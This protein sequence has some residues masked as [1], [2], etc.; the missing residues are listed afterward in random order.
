MSLFRVTESNEV[1]SGYLPARVTFRV[2]EDPKQYL[3]LAQS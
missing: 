1:Y 2:L 3:I